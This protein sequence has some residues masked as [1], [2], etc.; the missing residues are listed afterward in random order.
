MPRGDRNPRE[1]LRDAFRPDQGLN[2]TFFRSELPKV[3]LVIALALLLKAFF[4]NDTSSEKSA[5]EWLTEPIAAPD[6]AACKNAL[7]DA[8]AAAP[9]GFRQGMEDRIRFLA[10]ATLRSAGNPPD[11]RTS[12]NGSAWA[13]LLNMGS[14]VACNTARRETPFTLMHIVVAEDALRKEHPDWHNDFTAL[15]EAH[16]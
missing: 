13:N 15:C 16:R 4:F 12:E 2:R 9:A 1:E 7:A 8:V 11:R 10:Y 14:D 6:A 5:D 3:L